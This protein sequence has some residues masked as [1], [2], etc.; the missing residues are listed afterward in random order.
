MSRPV[1]ALHVPTLPE[2]YSSVGDVH[3]NW[4]VVE[5]PSKTS[6]PLSPVFSSVGTP[7]CR[8]VTGSVLNVN[9]DGPR[10]GE[11]GTTQVLSGTAVTD[12]LGEGYVYGGTGMNPSFTGQGSTRYF[13]SL[14]RKRSRRRRRSRP[15]DHHRLWAN[16]PSPKEDASDTPETDLGFYKRHPV[17]TCLPSCHHN[18]GLRT[19]GWVG[20]RSGVPS[21]RWTRSV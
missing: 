20:T 8:S 15:F 21:L 16:L 2:G 10:T 19:G 9:R 3:Q 7:V 12:R 6:G 1:P 4:G 14:R 18:P 13:R 5:N 11:L 17:F